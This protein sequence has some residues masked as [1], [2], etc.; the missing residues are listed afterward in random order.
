MKSE[1]SFPL[2]AINKKLPPFKAKK[3]RHAKVNGR[4]CRVLLPSLCAARIFQL[5]HELG[6]KTHGETIGWL[7]RQA[8]PSI[9]ATIG[10]TMSSPVDTPNSIVVAPASASVLPSPAKDKTTGQDANSAAMFEGIKFEQASPPF[11][12]DLF[13]N[14]DVEFFNSEIAML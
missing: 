9:I 8:E 13:A 7:L 10:T 5:T 1:T 14:F 2:K 6:Y 12:F 11:E 3:D 4:E